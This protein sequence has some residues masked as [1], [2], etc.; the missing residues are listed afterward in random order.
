VEDD[1]IKGIIYITSQ[2]GEKGSN[3]R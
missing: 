1:S 3:E 2:V